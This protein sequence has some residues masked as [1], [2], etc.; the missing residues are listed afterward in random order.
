MR[1]V[2]VVSEGTMDKLK[3]YGKSTVAVKF[4]IRGTYGDHSKCTMCRGI[5]AEDFTVYKNLIFFK[6][7]QYEV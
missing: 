5:M 1:P 3:K 7:V 6:R 4:Q 2:S